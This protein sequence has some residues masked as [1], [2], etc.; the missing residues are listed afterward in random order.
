MNLFVPRP[1]SVTEFNGVPSLPRVL[2]RR[3]R[4]SRFGRHVII[5]AGGT[6][7]G[8]AVA[9]LASPLLAR[10]YQPSDFGLLSVFMSLIL[11]LGTVACLNYEAAIPLPKDDELGLNV[12]GISFGVL[13][14][15]TLICGG[16]V[17]FFGKQV[18]QLLRTPSL[19]RYLW[20]L[21]LS[22]LGGGAFLILN[23]WA[24]R[25]QAFRALA[26]RRV[27]QSVAQTLTQLGVPHI[28]GG[29]FGLL[30]GDAVGRASGSWVLALDARKY[31]AERGLRLSARKIA[32]AAN[33]YRRFPVF[34]SASVLVHVSFFALPP[35]LL[36]RLFGLREAGWYGLI[37]QLGGAGIGL[38]GGSIGQVYVSNAAQLAHSSPTQLRALFLRT[39]R[40]TFMMAVIPFGLLLFFGPP[41]FEFVFGPRWIEAGRYAQLL[42]L[43]YLAVLTVSPVF[44]ALT[45]LERQD[46]QLVVD[47]VGV[48]MMIFG[49]YYA[50]HLGLSGRWGVAAYGVSVFVTYL[51]LFLLALMAIQGR[52]KQSTRPN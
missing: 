4:A 7:A 26:K 11:A 17:L 32:E 30:L 37:N 19:G 22:L 3:V 42:A 10:I 20:L 23:S 40:A 1:G 21:P 43:P 25:L 51:A 45:V 38:I 39:S 6:I 35:L 52:C 27:F 49:M 44:P 12:M 48:V 5:I 41:L 9:T 2:Y 16:V 8:R 14:L 18:C 13:F 28:V 24:V 31:A 34:G 47:T 50:H 29:P 36:T 46:W 15:N 33:R